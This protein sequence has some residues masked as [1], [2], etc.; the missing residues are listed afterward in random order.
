MLWIVT[1]CPHLPPVAAA[2][3]AAAAVVVVVPYSSAPPLSW[4]PF[5]NYLL[6]SF[7]E[8]SVVVPNLLESWVICNSVVVLGII[9]EMHILVVFVGTVVGMVVVVGIGVVRL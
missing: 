8:N 6:H 2:A 5:P 7:V 9:L 4:Q 1:T 3:A